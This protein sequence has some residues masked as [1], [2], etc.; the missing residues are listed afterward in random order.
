MQLNEEMYMIVRYEGW[1]SQKTL[2][3]L[4]PWEIN[5]G[6]NQQKL[7]NGA[8]LIK[9][10]ENHRIQEHHDKNN[11]LSSHRIITGEEQETIC[12]SFRAQ[13]QKLPK[14][15][16]N[17]QTK[18]KNIKNKKALDNCKQEYLLILEYEQRIVNLCRK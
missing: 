10:I 13:K 3:T 17:K 7:E 2:I 16:T 12:N 9:S 5:T 14:N 4:I 18:R 8:K 6:K 1:A 15:H 11:I